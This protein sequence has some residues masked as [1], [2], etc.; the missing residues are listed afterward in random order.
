MERVRRKLAGGPT[1][2]KPGKGDYR[3][4]KAYRCISLNCLG[5]TVEMVA[6]ALISKHCKSSGGFH[7]ASTVAGLSDQQPTRLEPPSCRPKRPGT[8]ESFPEPS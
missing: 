8:E 5:K 3:L 4:A 2:P 7:P 1:I 6:A